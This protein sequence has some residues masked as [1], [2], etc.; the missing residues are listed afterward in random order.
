MEGEGKQQR[1]TDE[2]AHSRNDAEDQ[3]DRDAKRQEREARGVGDYVGGLG[4]HRQHVDFHHPSL[5]IP[6]NRYPFRP[7]RPFLT[8]HPKNVQ[9]LI[10][11]A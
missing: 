2:A 7:C 3:T 4:R 10:L 6:A 1:Q 8:A 5:F 11:T 9:A